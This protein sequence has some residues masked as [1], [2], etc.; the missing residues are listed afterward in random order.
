MI[1]NYTIMFLRIIGLIIMEIV[2]ISSKGQIVVPKYIRDA[3][4]LKSGDELI[5]SRAEDRIIMMKKPSDPIEGLRKAGE[6]VAIKNVRRRI[7]GE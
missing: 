5:V 1:V 2:T 6:R 7:K 3:L 4:L